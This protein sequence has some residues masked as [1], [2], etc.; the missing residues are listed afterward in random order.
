MQL[1]KRLFQFVVFALV[2]L[3][4]AQPLLADTACTQQRCEGTDCSLHFDSM[5]IPNS[6]MPPILASSQ[7][8]PQV[9]FAEAGCSYGLCWLRSDSATLLLATPP[10]FR[11]ARS[12]TFY[13]PVVQF[14]ASRA[15]ILAA[16]PFEDA[17][18]G[19]VP[20]NILFQV[21]RI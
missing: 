1:M 2:L 5:A 11:L 10:T 17:A 8:T 13:M 16:R 20:K 18:T 12:S 15:V 6:A 19:A 3:A 9:V 14:S 7:A 21:F 4:A